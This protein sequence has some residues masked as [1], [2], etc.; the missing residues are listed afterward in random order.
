MESIVFARRRWVTP[1]ETAIHIIRAIRVMTVAIFRAE[2]TFPGAAFYSAIGAAIQQMGVFM[3]RKS[4]AIVSRKAIIVTLLTAALSTS[5]LAYQAPSTGLGQAWPNAT[6]VSVSSHYH[7]YVFVRDGIRYIQVNDLSGT[8]LGAVA[9]ADNEVLVMPVGADAQ[10]VTTSPAD[11]QTTRKASNAETVYNDGA[12]QVTA[13]PASD[14]AV[15]INV[16]AH[17]VCQDPTDCTGSVISHIG[18]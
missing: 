8:V 16:V 14:G 18:S 6:D 9:V 2:S 5:A 10:Y 13:V 12:T 1:I 17:N 4:H 15:Q 3:F 7:V 11:S